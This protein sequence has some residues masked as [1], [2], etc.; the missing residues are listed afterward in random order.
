MVRSHRN[1]G[2]DQHAKKVTVASTIGGRK[3]HQT[4]MT[5]GTKKDTRIVGTTRWEE[6]Q[7]CIKL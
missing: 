3:T 2:G 7:F 1:N 4:G 5:E 6:N